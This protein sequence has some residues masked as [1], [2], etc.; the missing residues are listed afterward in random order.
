MLSGR[1][2]QREGATYL[3]A[4]WPYLF[5]LESLG[6]GTSR[7]DLV[8]DLRRRE[9]LCFW[10]RSERWGGGGGGGGRGGVILNRPVSGRENFV[11]DPF[12]DGKSMK[13][14]KNGSD[15]VRVFLHFT[16]V[17]AAAFCTACRR[18]ICFWGSP[19]RRLLQ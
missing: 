6:P 11:A 16:T 10:R 12:L 1:T 14:C 4:R 17:L 13:P 5:I 15:M 2:F 19:D 8:A 7:R 3:K 9:G 18:L